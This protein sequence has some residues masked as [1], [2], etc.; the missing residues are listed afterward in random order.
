MDIKA[1]DTIAWLRAWRYRCCPPADILHGKSDAR[2]REHLQLCPWCRQDRKDGQLNFET[3]SLATIPQDQQDPGPGQLWAVSPHLGDWGPKGRYY[4]P[5]VVIIVECPDQNALTVVQTYD[6]LVFAGMND[7]P[8]N[9]EFS[10]FAEPWNCYTIRR[11]DLG[12]YLGRISDDLLRTLQ[13]PL[14]RENNTP[15]TGSLVW[16]FRQMEVETGFFFASKAVEELMAEYERD[17][18]KHLEKIRQQ[19]RILQYEGRGEMTADLKR[20]PI[21]LPAFPVGEF[22]PLVMLALSQPADD[23]L[24]LVAMDNKKRATALVFTVENGRITDVSA[25]ELYVDHI[26]CSGDMLHITGS[27]PD[28][29]PGFSFFFFWQI[30]DHIVEP[31][32]GEA[33]I[34]DSIFWAVFPVREVNDPMQGTLVVRILNQGK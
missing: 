10:G 27:M 34:Q 2:L 11:E 23:L 18:E 28:T 6:D 9:N 30:G 31:L 4:S 14:T 17:E 1:S 24:P 13:Q 8:L 32:P 26:S 19:S 16:F 20:L 21:I 25:R 15:E 3:S 7:L 12:F 5:P 33:G 29:E 22:S